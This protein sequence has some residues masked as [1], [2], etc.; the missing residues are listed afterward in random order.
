MQIHLKMYIIIMWTGFQ[1]ILPAGRLPI[2]FF[3]GLILAPWSLVFL[4]AVSSG[5]LLFSIVINDVCDSVCNAT[6]LLCADGFKIFRYIINV[7][8][9]RLL[10]SDIDCV[11]KWCLDN[12]LNVSV[13]KSTFIYFT[14]RTNS[15]ACKYKIGVTH[16]ALK[17][18]GY[19]R[20]LHFIFTTVLITL[21]LK[22]LTPYVSF[23]TWRLL[24]PWTP[25]LPCLALL[26]VIKSNLP[27]SLGI[28]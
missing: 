19:C 23:A 8:D 17:I 13:D 10:Q 20:P 9:Y 28:L 21:W 3:F 22:P 1:V 11:H 16:L 4:R 24:L 18:L 15:I 5:T 7:E 6:C 12:G 26:S 2:G 25:S 14:R 27:L